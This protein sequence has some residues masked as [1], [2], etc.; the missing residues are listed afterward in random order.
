VVF[1]FYIVIWMRA[2]EEGP[3]KYRDACSCP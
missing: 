2:L 3:T 1:L